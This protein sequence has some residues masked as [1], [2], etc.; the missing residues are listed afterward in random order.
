MAQVFK[1]P[2]TSTLVDENGQPSGDNVFNLV[3][4]ANG[5]INSRSSTHGSN[6]VSGKSA[7]GEFAVITIRDSDGS[8]YDGVMAVNLPGY[9]VIY[10]LKTLNADEK[11]A[12]RTAAGRDKKEA[13]ERLL[14]QEQ[15]IWVATK[16]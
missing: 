11:A 8:R 4:E 9:K 2:W 3:I 16:P 15:I 6:P 7:N 14:T 12:E 1:G 10:G 5:Q 13:K